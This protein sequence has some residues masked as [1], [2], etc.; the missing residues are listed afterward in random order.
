MGS[1]SP[2]PTT[3][4]ARPW[5]L[6]SKRE[7]QNRKRLR[8]IRRSSQTIPRPSRPTYGRASKG[9]EKLGGA[10]LLVVCKKMAPQV[11]L[12]PTT[13]RLTAGRTVCRLLIL[14]GVTTAG[15]CQNRYAWWV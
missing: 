13:L 2:S 5:S 12:E 3:R 14:K 10:V 15:R 11:G 9:G 8:G 1:F 6:S 4:P 7:R